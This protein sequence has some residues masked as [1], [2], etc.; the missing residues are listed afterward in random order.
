MAQEWQAAHP[1]EPIVMVQ[2]GW[3]NH[4]EVKSG[5]TDPFVAGV[6]SGGAKATDPGCPDASKGAG[7]A[8]QIL[9]GLGEQHPGINPN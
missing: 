8:E 7:A 3:P 9:K 1:D 5:R 6:L 2:L 4:T